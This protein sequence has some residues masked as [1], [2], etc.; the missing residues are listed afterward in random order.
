MPPPDRKP[1]PAPRPKRP[2]R[3][4]QR[5]RDAHASELSEDYAEAIARTIRDH[6]ECRV[7]HLAHTFGVSHVTVVRTVQRLV[8]QGLANTQP[9]QP[10]HLTPAG[11]RLAAHAEHRHNIVLEFLL[12][13][14]VDEHTAHADAEGI[15]HHI[16]PQTLRKLETF[17]KTA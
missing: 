11:R 13:L 5:V 4:F 1:H 2:A 6:G 9:H 8:D 10:I 17:L 16:S 14:G 3:A 12:A 7:K 15:E